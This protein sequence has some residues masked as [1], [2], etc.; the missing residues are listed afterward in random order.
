MCLLVQDRRSSRSC[1]EW[2][3]N[4][5]ATGAVCAVCAAFERYINNTWREPWSVEL[6]RSYL[7]QHTIMHRTI[8][9]W[10]RLSFF[11]HFFRYL[12]YSFTLTLFRSVA[13]SCDSYT[14]THTHTHTH[15][16][17]FYFILFSFDA[18]LPGEFP[19]LSLSSPSP[20]SCSLVCE[21]ELTRWECRTTI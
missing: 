12:A 1:R 14:Y 16:H 17:F 10:N 7:S 19:R 4:E 2:P 15:T 18:P 11:S 9:N 21:E 6:R 13:A 3:V 20:W 5:M 8:T